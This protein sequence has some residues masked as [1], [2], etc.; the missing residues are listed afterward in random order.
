MEGYFS[1]LV[2][3]HCNVSLLGAENNH[4]FQIN[5]KTENPSQVFVPIM[6]GCDKFCTYC[7]VPYTRGRESSRPM[8]EIF[9]ECKRHVEN[10]A[11]EIT[12]LGQNVN[13]YTENGKKCFGDLLRKIDTLCIS[14]V[15]ALN[16]GA[17]T[18]V[19]LSRLRY[20]SPHPQDFTDDVI[21][22]LA[23]M[24]TACPYIHLPVQ[25]GSDTILKSMNRNYTVEEYLDLVDKIRKKIPNCAI[26]TDVIVGFPGEMDVDFEALCELGR[27]AEFS[28][29]YTAIFSPRKNTPA[30]K[31]KDEFVPLE[32]K[33]KRFAVFDKIVKETS[34]N[35][36][37]QYVGKSLEVLV[38][39]SELTSGGNYKNTGRSREYFEVQFVS[40]RSYF[41]QE[42]VVDIEKRMNY[43]LMGKLEEG[44]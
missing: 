13:S 10:G 44:G 23:E 36:R 33:R 28:F 40:G 34:W 11:K 30:D 17:S 32:I 4:Y 19:G 22:V 6:Q 20:T 21:D 24:K 5:P 7:I 12:L 39:S 14:D 38:E 35:L 3:T 16:L 15:E 1:D 26:A 27:K 31:M 2:E 8:D 25:H 29:S 43:T 37:D 18:S 42:V 41:G 9:E